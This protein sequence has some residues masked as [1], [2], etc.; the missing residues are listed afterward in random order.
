MKSQAS[1]TLKATQQ[2]KNLHSKFRELPMLSGWLWF[3]VSNI[4]C[5]TTCSN[6][7]NFV[8]GSVDKKCLHVTFMQLTSRKDQMPQKKNARTSRT[9]RCGHA[10]WDVTMFLR[11]EAC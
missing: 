10:R 5:G 6:A 7:G 2:S 8:A 9:S 4:T 11:W 3:G 1:E